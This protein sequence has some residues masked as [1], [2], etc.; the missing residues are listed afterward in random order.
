MKYLCHSSR[1]HILTAVFL[2]VVVFSC[3]DNSNNVK[4]TDNDSLS[5][6]TTNTI[7]EDELNLFDDE[8]ISKKADELFDDFFYNF[9]TDNRF[10][11][12]RI[13]KALKKHKN[14]ILEMFSNQDFF[15]VIYEDTKDLVLLKDTTL[16]NV[17]VEWI[18]LENEVEDKYNFRKI[19]GEWILAG[20]S[21]GGLM[22]AD[23]IDFYEFYK[24]FATDRDF[25][26]SSLAEE[27]RYHAEAQEGNE[28]V[29]TILTHKD[30]WE[31]SM[32]MPP[33][34]PVIVNINYGQKL[35]GNNVRN[36]LFEGL[37]NGISVNY[38]FTKEDDSWILTDI[39]I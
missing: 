10:Q 31:F 29:D 3:K 26:I 37:C 25:Q 14:D 36:L 22:Y 30:W 13:D 38:C 20:K 39:E 7:I 33:F 17:T 19:N 9:I 4:Q 8:P 35:S 15:T 18:D 6:D 28:A 12:I 32:E 1:L 5:V 16:K 2:T 27:I 23:N 34:N 21:E 24:K 11:S